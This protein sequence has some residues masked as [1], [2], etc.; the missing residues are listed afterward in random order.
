MKQCELCGIEFEAQRDSAKYCSAKCRVT[1]SRK[2]SLVT[3]NVT[4]S[5]PDVTLSLYFEFYTI[6]KANGLGRKE[7]EKLGTRKVKYWYDVPLGAIPVIKKD[8]PKMPEFM[9]GRQYFLWWKNDFKINEQGDPI[10]HNPHPA[11]DNV[12]Y[13]Q[14]GDNSRRWGA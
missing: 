11:R 10:I 1:A 4:L 13:V 3:P 6:S 8:W 9:N 14:A 7:D 2:G 5:D 12:T